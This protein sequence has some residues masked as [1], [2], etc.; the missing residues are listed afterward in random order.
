MC[1]TCGC[2]NKEHADHDH[3]HGHDHEHDHDHK[4]EGSFTHR[5]GPGEPEHTHD[6][7]SVSVRERILAR[8]DEAAA[9]NRA[10]LAEHGIVAL[11]LIS[12]PGSGKTLLLERTLERLRGRVRCAVI[13]GDLQTDNDARRLHGKGAD[14]RQIETGSACHLDAE[15]IGR[16]LPE[17]TS[18]GVKLL[19]VENVGNLVCPA[20]F[21]LGE[22]FKIALLSTAEGE[23]KPVKY[24]TLFSQAPVVVLTKID[25]AEVLDWNGPACRDNIRR[26]HPGVFVFELSARTGTGMDAWVAYLENLVS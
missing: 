18:G 22:S 26:V 23:D 19:F 24:P 14:V 21:D 20:A 8:N 11:N 25:L 2:G 12:A 5:H 16:L 6:T 13:T 15:Q 9:R 7:R 10:W 3:D 4:H 1:E 17:I